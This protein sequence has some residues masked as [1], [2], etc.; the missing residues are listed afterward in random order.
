MI[1]RDPAPAGAKN[2]PLPLARIDHRFNREHH[3]GSN[4]ETGL[5]LAVMQNLRVFMIHAA[6]SMSAVF[7][8]HRKSLAFGQA[9]IA[10]PMS[11]RWAP[12]RTSSIARHM[13]SLH[14][15]ARRCP[16]TGGLPTKYMRLVSP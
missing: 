9:L 3:S 12:G 6:D 16:S 1:F 4:L 14:T 8:H 15:S 7:A 10:W 5:G 2:A 11:P 13:A